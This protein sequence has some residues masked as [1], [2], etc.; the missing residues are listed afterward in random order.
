[1][2]T[3]PL[4]RTGLTV[5]QLC[6][7]TMT[8]GTQVS[9][10]DGHRQM[11]VSVAHGVNFFDTAELYS[12]VPVSAET[13]GDSERIVGTWLAQRGRRDDVIVAT[14]L[15]GAGVG[16]IRN[17]APMSGAVLTEAVEAS[18][19]RLQTDVIDLYQL[20]WPNRGHY[21]FRRQWNYDPTDQVT[22]DV[23]A[24]IADMLGVLGDLVNAG[25][26]RAIGLS[27]ETAWGTM[28]FLQMAEAGGLPRVASVQNEYSLL[29]RPHD[30][31]FAELSH[32]EDVGLLAYSPLAA[33]VLSG[34][35]SG[36]ALPPHSRGTVNAGMGG[37]LND[38]ALAAADAYTALAREYEM[39]PCVMALAFCMSRPFMTSAI[40]GATSEAQL[41][42]ALLAAE[43]T[44]SDDLLARI[45][46][47]HRA[48]PS[49]Y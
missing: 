7:G 16:H 33:G 29:Y 12:T 20:H 43:T 17:G 23:E 8:M 30:L 37:R 1:M 26:I 21:H 10:T 27:N 36:G 45:S 15:S 18:L 14:K 47:I 35:Y 28:K 48:H 38:R 31:D 41:E 11:D 5:P 39:D 32:H 9:E 40:F 22:S 24:H 25:K 2:K 34:K 46:A 13:Q 19:A 3:M 44:L 6:L 42:T 49:P 4:G